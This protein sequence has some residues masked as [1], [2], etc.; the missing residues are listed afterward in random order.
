M[1]TQARQ[2][3]LAAPGKSRCENGVFRDKPDVRL[4]HFNRALVAEER[5][6]AERAIAEYNQDLETHPDTDKAAFNLGRIFGRRGD[7][8]AEIDALR[9]SR[10]SIPISP[11]S[12][13]F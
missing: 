5:G 1:C 2:G 7:H 9:R 12:T 13:C 8:R 11:K 10:R 4:A 6:D 3:G